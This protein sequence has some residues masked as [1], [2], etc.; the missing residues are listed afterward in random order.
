MQGLA[1]SR[2]LDPS[3]AYFPLAAD[4]ASSRSK[5]SSARRKA[6]WT[7]SQMFSAPT[8]SSKSA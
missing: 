5:T 6:S 4:L 8:T 2:E 3:E 7:F 1:R